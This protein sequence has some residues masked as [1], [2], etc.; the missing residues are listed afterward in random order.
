M[1]R[2]INIRSRCFP[3]WIEQGKVNRIDAQDRLD[4]LATA[5]LVLEFAAKADGLEEQIDSYL[6]GKNGPAPT[7]DAKQGKVKT[8]T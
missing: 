5:L 1:E 8:E 6:T 3:M 7:K 2:E 4:R